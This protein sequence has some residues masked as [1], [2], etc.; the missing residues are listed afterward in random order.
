MSLVEPSPERL[1]QSQ[2]MFARKEDR[3]FSHIYPSLLQVSLCGARPDD[4][5]EV[6]VHA[7]EEGGY[8]GWWDSKKDYF[9]MIWQSKVQSDLCFQ[10][11]SGVEV[12][13]AAGRGKQL[14]FRVEIVED[15]S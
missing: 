7:D 14:R 13:E 1:A 15:V 6:E 4:I 9:T 2:R 10:G 12:A 11:P 5:V 8:W 3:G